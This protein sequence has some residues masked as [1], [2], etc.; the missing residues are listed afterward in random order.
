MISRF[1]IDRP[2][3]ATV[4]SIIITIAG[5]AAIFNLP[6]AQYP[7]ITPPTVQVSA[8]Y[9][10]A[11]A[12]VV[13]QTVAAPIEEQING[14]EGMLYLSSSSSS[15]GSVSITVTF[16]TGTDPEQATINVNNRIQQV[17]SKMP[18]EVKN[19]GI[20]VNKS[21]STMLE[22]ISLS[23][24]DNSY[25]VLELT[26]Y[27]IINI[28]DELKRVEGVGNAQAFGGGEY[29]IRIW[30]KPDR[31]QHLKVT[32]TDIANV[33]R[34]QNSQFT[35]GK[36]GQ[37]PID[38]PVQMTYTVTTKG[39]LTEVSEFENIIVRADPDG[40]ILRLKDIADVELGPQDYDMVSKE[41]GKAA[42][43]LAIHMQPGANALDVSTSVNKAMEE[44]SKKFPPGIK[45]SIVV[46]NT[47]Y[48][49]ESIK[50]VI[51]TLVIAMLLVF[52]VVYVFL[53][54]WRA[55]LIPCLAIP[56]SLIGAFAGMY[57]MGFSINT[58]T[59]L[60]MILS[61]GIVVDD[62]I[63]V[64]EN[65]ERIMFEEG[66]LPK[67]ATRKA[68]DQVSGPI[69]AIVLVL[70]AVFV[71]VGFLGGMT[72]QLYKQFAI[73]IAMSVAI[74]GFVAL[75]LSPALCGVLLKPS[76]KMH[77]GFFKLF[78][79]S[80]EWFRR[81]YTD[82]VVFA[83]KRAIL[84]LVIM[85][86]MVFVTYML[87]RSIPS[88]FIPSEDQGMFIGSITLPDAASIGRT[89][90][91]SD[92][93]VEKAMKNPLIRKTMAMNGRDMVG[94]GQKTYAATLMVEL[95]PWDERKTADAKLDRQVQRFIME[96]SV[97]K[98]GS[99]IAFS[100]AGIQGLG[101]I[102]GFELYIQNRGGGDAKQLAEVAQRLTAAAS[103]RPEL[104]TVTSMFRANVPQLY[105]DVDRDKAKVYG[106]EIGNIFDAMQS[107]FGT[108]YVND[109][110]KSGRTFKV[111]LQAD[112]S[113]RRTPDDINNVYVRSS[114]TNG[115]IPLKSL[116]DVKYITGPEQIDRFNIFPSAHVNGNAAPGYSS[117]EAMTAM[118][119]VAKEVLP[120]D[121]GY[122]WSG[123]SY[124]EKKASGTSILAFAFG[125]VMVF[126]ILAALYEKWSL[127]LS[128]I[129]VVPFGLFGAMLIL[130]L[131]GFSNDIYF[132]ISLLVLIGL[133][134]KNAILIVEFASRKHMEGVS[135]FDAAVEAARLRL[136]PIVMTSIAFILGAMPLALA[137]GAGAASRRSIGTGIVGGMLSATFLAIFFV[138]LFFKLVTG[139][140]K[141]EIQKEIP[142]EA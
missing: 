97:F 119:E 72:G 14:V 22:I 134:A 66:L 136:R 142:G 128:V 85:A 56:V 11:S 82:G 96:S 44:L 51:T 115:M 108:L 141:G 121:Y 69:I 49:R 138:P 26:N 1:F 140:K 135:V 139:D 45:Y 3:F 15:N 2:I 65:V 36:V 109:F 79:M 94:G 17:M 122:A 92:K 23:S 102:G 73:T 103:K 33:I 18:Q 80:F 87:F 110:N 78:N 77:H 19:Q 5:V 4:L 54:N 105:M 13:Q 47:R 34:E 106:V 21:M 52:L 83:L 38:K 37:N 101:M 86:A 28:L 63:V 93:V 29:S 70:C 9:P 130:W 120:S 41:N 67:E 50:E 42:V 20:T 71:P 125:I 7:D 81:R 43:P 137:T 107:T 126:L 24:P 111:Q 30:L 16:E 113:Y 60:G 76:H 64:L 91:L 8:T 12:E 27:A 53:Q 129:M 68:M 89:V 32:A 58:L 104:S 84:C 88:S 57:L 6:V 131:R 95:A 62:A 39:R 123:M 127:P 40:S 124:Q 48:V 55:T 59:L 99:V 90:A 118:E 10:G 116:M 117:G 98:E 61:V 25:G 46:D 133:S 31:M 75:T 112:A 132:Q 114:T 35:A 100:P 74:S